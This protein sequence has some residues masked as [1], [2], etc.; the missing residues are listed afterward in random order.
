MNRRTFVKAVGGIAGIM[1]VPGVALA[2]KQ[3]ENVFTAYEWT[4][5]WKA[6]IHRALEVKLRTVAMF[7]QAKDN[8]IFL[9]GDGTSPELCGTIKAIDG[10]QNTPPTT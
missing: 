1:A 7:E 9:Y 5:E 3:T 4:D 8:H 2:T 10:T 6:C